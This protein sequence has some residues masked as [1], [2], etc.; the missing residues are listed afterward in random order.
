MA[1][2]DYICPTHGVFEVVQKM[3][4]VAPN[5]PCPACGRASRRKFHPVPDNWTEI[6]GSHRHTYGRGNVTGDKATRLN[7]NWSRAW[8]EAPPP[9]ATDYTDKVD[10][11]IK[12][13]A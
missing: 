3:S 2:Y 10:V 5:A 6:E 1:R 12:R 9:P 7:Q 8:G 13:Q 11:T 4:D